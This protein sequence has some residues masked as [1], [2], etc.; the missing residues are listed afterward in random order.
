MRRQIRPFS[1]GVKSFQKLVLPINSRDQILDVL[2]VDEMII[3]YAI[4]DADE[5]LIE[6]HDVLIVRNS[7]DL[8]VRCTKQSHVASLVSPDGYAVHVF[9]APHREPIIPEAT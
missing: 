2:L 9:L 8:S 3:L 6:K 7:T 4:V 1:L 5:T